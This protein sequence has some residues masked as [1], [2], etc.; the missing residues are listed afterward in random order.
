MIFINSYKASKIDLFQ[1]CGAFQRLLNEFVSNGLKINNID[2][3]L[4]Q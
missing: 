3:E 1:F 2:Q 4:T